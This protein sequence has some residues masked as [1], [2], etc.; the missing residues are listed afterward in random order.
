MRLT[1]WKPLFLFCAAVTVSGVAMGQQPNEPSLWSSSAEPAQ[2]QQNDPL[3]MELGQAGL[4]TLQTMSLGRAEAPTLRLAL[5]ELAESHGLV[6]RSMDAVV[7]S[8]QGSASAWLVEL[9]SVVPTESRLFLYYLPDSESLYFLRT[10][11]LDDM[12]QSVR[13]WGSGSSELVMKRDGIALVDG[14]I[15]KTFRLNSPFPNRADK[16]SDTIACLGH[17]LGLTPTPTALG[18]LLARTSCGATNLLS[19]ALTTYN[20]LSI[21]HPIATVGCIVG[22]GKLMRL[23]ELQLSCGKRDGRVDYS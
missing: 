10:E 2:W 4:G 21:P 15:G 22:V 14:P 5:D 11:T 20:C 16:V 17:Q 3:L 6:P 7:L 1:E 9:V 12:G 18:D 8:G 23:C 19:L 13:I